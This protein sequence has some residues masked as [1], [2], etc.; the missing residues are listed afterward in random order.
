MNNSPPFPEPTPVSQLAAAADCN[1]RIRL[2]GGAN[3]LSAAQSAGAR[4]YVRQ[5]IGFWAAPGPGLADEETPLALDVSPAVS[6]DARVVTQLESQVL[7][8]TNVEAIALQLT[9]IRPLRHERVA[10]TFEPEQ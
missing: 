8:T 7:G 1:T 4:R 9:V 5:S 2:E 3:V 10:I 6:A